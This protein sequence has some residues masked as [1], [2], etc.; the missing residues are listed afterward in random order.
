MDTLQLT[1]MD[2]GNRCAS[3]W[4]PFGA[5]LIMEIYTDNQV[6]FVYNGRVAS[7]EGIGECR[8]KALCSYEAIVHHLTHIV[9]SESE[10]RG[11][12]VTHE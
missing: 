12:R 6:R 11:S 9:P 10:C 3:S 2:S 1:W 7:V 5:L 8:G 4:P